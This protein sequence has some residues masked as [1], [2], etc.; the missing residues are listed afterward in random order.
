MQ[1]LTLYLYEA[2]DPN[3]SIPVRGSWFAPNE[4]KARFWLEQQGF[5]EV[6]LRLSSKSQETLRVH[7]TALAL[8]FRQLG[9][10]MQ[11]STPL[12]YALRLVSHSQDQRLSGVARL[13][14]TNVGNGQYLSKAM[15]TF[16]LVFDKVIVG[17]VAAGEDSGRL[18]ATL[19][20][21]AAAEE[22]RVAL[23]SRVISSLTYPLVLTSFTL[24]VTGVF[25]C[26]V[27]P[28]DVEL[29]GSMG[30][31][32]PAVHRL[33][34][35]VVGIFNSPWL[36]LLLLMFCGGL[37]A[38]GRLEANR[39]RLWRA[40]TRLVGWLPLARDLLHKGRSVR[41]LQILSLVLTSGGSVEQAMKLMSSAYAD[42]PDIE[43]A[44]EGL[45]NE[46]VRGL[47]LGVAL[48]RSG[49]F[50]P[51]VGALLRIGVE[52]GRLDQMSERA[53]EICED[54]VR[55]GLDTLSSLLEPVLLALSGVVAAFL[56]I[57]AAM[58]MLKLLQ[59]L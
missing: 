33:L 1:Q 14:E 7:P 4:S 47:D 43:E 57:T 27:L 15:S 58:P 39:R 36:P 32:L 9:V 6:R 48:D 17:L 25:M 21:I 23:R 29:L 34:L 11:S 55:I 20:D 40:V 56:V 10:L 51:M 8:F 37:W 13:L 28:L 44:I 12:P 3:R 38:A 42:Q 45:R 16:P 52:A 18:A 19:L 35:W 30:V 31:E 53:Q 54:D 46:V 26:Y 50:P 41:L 24:G 49:L 59:A 2:Y 5:V 22:R